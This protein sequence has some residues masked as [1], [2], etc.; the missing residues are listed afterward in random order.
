M[1]FRHRGEPGTFSSGDYKCFELLGKGYYGFVVKCSKISTTRPVVIK[2]NR[3]CT[4]RVT[5]NEIDILKALKDGPNV[6]PLVDEVREG[7]KVFIIMDLFNG[8]SLG[9]IEERLTMDKVKKIWYE[10]FRTVAYANEKNIFHEDLHANNVMVNLTTMEV[11]VFDWG[12]SSK[13]FNNKAVPAAKRFVDVNNVGHSLLLKVLQTNGIANRTTA[14]TAAKEYLD[15]VA[16]TDKI[17]QDKKD[18][19][20]KHSLQQVDEATWD[21][22]ERVL[23]KD[24]A[25][26]LTATQALEHSF[27]DG[28]RSNSSSSNNSIPTPPLT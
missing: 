19:V 14:D 2:S 17:G 8:S 24:P 18:W 27:W 20:I 16:T 13:Y 4:S 11:R 10:I 28:V 3:N 15:R 6:I 1:L 21:L 7:G 5:K 26:F 9:R 22:L 23:T 25:K 12:L